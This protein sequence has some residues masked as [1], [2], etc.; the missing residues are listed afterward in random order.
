MNRLMLQDRNFRLNYLEELVS[1]ENTI[2][3]GLAEFSLMMV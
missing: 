3:K 2:G 1:Q